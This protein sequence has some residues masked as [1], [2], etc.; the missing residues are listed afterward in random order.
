MAADKTTK[1]T[2]TAR[3]SKDHLE[4]WDK[5]ERKSSMVDLALQLAKTFPHPDDVC[6]FLRKA[7]SEREKASGNN[8]E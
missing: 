4:T 1:I 3:I 5:L 2:R 8:Q 7:I 6:T